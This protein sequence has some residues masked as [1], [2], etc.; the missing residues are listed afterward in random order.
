MSTDDKIIKDAQYRKGLSIAFFNATN[1]AIAMLGEMKGGFEDDYK[2][3]F[4]EIRDW[5]LE[6]HKKYYSEVIASVGKNYDASKT[7]ELVKSAK[8][9]EELRAIYTA[10]SED[11]RHDGDI[12]KVVKEIKDKYEKS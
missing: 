8:N 11:E 3:H 12:R 4:T 1:S 10:M 2:N 6:E 5:M 7:I 9:W